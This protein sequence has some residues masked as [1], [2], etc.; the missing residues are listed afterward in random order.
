MTP[1]QIRLKTNLAVKKDESGVVMFDINNKVC[2]LLFVRSVCKLLRP[3][4]IFY[5]SL[6]F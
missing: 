5:L 3:R 4:R 1:K 6:K 2:L